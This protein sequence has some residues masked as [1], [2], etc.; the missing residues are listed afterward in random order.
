MDI[1]S[2]DTT[3]GKVYISN[4]DLIGLMPKRHEL[5][6]QKDFTIEVL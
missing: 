6:P 5:S 1:A 3:Q 4:P 2:I